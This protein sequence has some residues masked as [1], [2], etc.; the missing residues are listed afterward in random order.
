MTA[1]FE[2][3]PPALEELLHSCPI[4]RSSVPAANACSS[5]FICIH[6]FGAATVYTWRRNSRQTWRQTKV[7][8]IYLNPSKLLH[9]GNLITLVVQRKSSSAQAPRASSWT[10]MIWKYL[11]G[12]LEMFTSKPLTKVTQERP[13][14][15]PPGP[16]RRHHPPCSGPPWHSSAECPRSESS[17]ERGDLADVLPTLRGCFLQNGDPKT[18]PKTDR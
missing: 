8:S 6:P 14:S 17:E 5:G 10:K 7:T 2:V 15:V 3:Q 12:H 18:M 16:P 1:I 9:G 4:R 11:N 13:Y